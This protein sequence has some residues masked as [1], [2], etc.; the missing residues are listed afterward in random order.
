MSDDPSRDDDEGRDTSRRDGLHPAQP[1]DSLGPDGR[2]KTL[3][4]LSGTKAATTWLSRDTRGN[5]YV[6]VKVLAVEA[7]RNPGFDSKL[8]NLEPWSDHKGVA[9][10]ANLIDQFWLEGPNGSHLCKVLPLLGPAI[11][12][13][14]WVPVTF[15]PEVLRKMCLQVI[16]GF[17]LVHCL[18]ICHGNFCPANIHLK[19]QGVDDLSEEQLAAVL[20]QSAAQPSHQADSETQ[21]LTIV[22][23]VDWSRV[24]PKYFSTDI[25][26]A[27]FESSYDPRNPPEALG[28]P[29]SYRSPEVLIEGA[30]RADYKADNWALGCTLFELRTG[31]ELF[32][33]GPDTEVNG[34]LLAMIKTLG[35]IPEPLWSSWADRRLY[36][37]DDG[38][39]QFMDDD[40]AASSPLE[41]LLTE[42]S[43]TAASRNGPID[44]GE[45]KLLADLL[46]QLLRYQADDRV[47]ADKAQ[48]HDWFKL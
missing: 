38:T 8:T 7:S 30:R 46:G 10:V 19:L 43:T 3:H 20:G 12:D 2:Y 47:R 48:H 37:Y 26:I 33:S 13:D 44:S 28:T 23:P 31:T 21:G 24:D 17:D 36:Y 42:S 32:G 34:V 22:Q 4:K 27:G 39:P 14:V 18:D 6:S 45:A 40:F 1:G 35:T 9:H 15:T 29:T 5:S 16:M 41:D 25:L 11:S